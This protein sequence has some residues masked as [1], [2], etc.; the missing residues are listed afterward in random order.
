MKMIVSGGL[1]ID[2]VI[3][4]DGEVR[5]RQKGGNVLYAGVGARLWIDEVALLA[6]VGENYPES[7][8]AA[9][10]RCGFN[11]DAVRRVPGWHDMRTFYAYVD[12]RTRVDREPA[13]HF[14]RV[15]HPLPPELEDYEHSLV[16]QRNQTDNPLMLRATD[17]PDDAETFG[18]AHVAPLGIVTQQELAETF[19]ARGIPQITLDPGEYEGTDENHDRIRRICAAVDAFLPSELE[20]G[21]LLGEYDDVRDIAIRLADLGPAIVVIKR[22]PQGCLIYERDPDRFTEI[23]PYPTSPVDVTGAGDSFC[24][25]FA[26][27]LRRTGDPVRAA[28][29]GTVSASFVIEGYGALYALDTPREGVQQRFEE[30]AREVR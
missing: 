8:E 29:M 17:V 24:G 4:A 7:W 10:D 23:P 15:G 30:L 2:Y 6:K 21:L 11:T 20:V 22:G 13:R 25:G 19:R 28:L 12:P 27:G 3:T 9:L 16:S 14:A 1:R 26:V 18:L 5:L